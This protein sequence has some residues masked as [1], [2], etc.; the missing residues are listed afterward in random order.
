MHVNK[1]AA[2][3]FKSI[4]RPLFIN[5]CALNNKVSITAG[6]CFKF[7]S[8]TKTYQR[9]SCKIAAARISKH[10]CFESMPNIPPLTQMNTYCAEP[11]QEKKH[12]FLKSVITK[13][14]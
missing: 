2:H 1:V 14:F 13:I 4:S 5:L 9:N 8:L 10:L 11:F 12:L 3:Y 7:W 6:I